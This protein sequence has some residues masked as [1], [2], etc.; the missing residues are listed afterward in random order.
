VE[1]FIS[2]PPYDALRKGADFPEFHETTY[3]ANSFQLG[4]LAEGSGSGDV[5]GFTLAAW[6]SARGAE[7]VIA[8]ATRD[9]FA[10]GAPQYGAS[11]VGRMNIGQTR[12]VC[13]VL[14]AP[15]DSPFLFQAPKTAA[16]EVEKGVAFIKLERTWL[17]VH[18]VN[19]RW[20]GVSAELTAKL[21]EKKP[22]EQ[23]LATQGTGG[24]LCGFALEA[25]E[26][27]S[28]GDYTAF[29]K[30]VLDGSKLDLAQ[31][32]V[33][34]VGFSGAKGEQVKVQFAESR[35][36]VWRQGVLHDWSKHQ[37]LYQGADGAKAPISLGW[38]EGALE[39]EASGQRFGCAVT[40]NGV[41]SFSH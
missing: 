33:G 18:P 27:E 26:Q 37:A 6:S 40:T 16:I 19:L 2:H 35:P 13:L 5:N 1:L 21:A 15:G 20:D 12:S 11:Q 28:H 7:F 31:A 14:N 22:G 41:V 30:A 9:P 17:A 38:K 36:I 10:I 8:N 4:T 39:V 24:K 23:I 25:G 29:R 32:G 3:I 34:T